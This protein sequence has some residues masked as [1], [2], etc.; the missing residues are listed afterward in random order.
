MRIQFVP[1]GSRQKSMLLK[2]FQPAFAL[3]TVL[4]V[5]TVM[6][7]VLLAAIQTSVS[8]SQTINSQYKEKISKEAA[9]SGIAMAKACLA[10]PPYSI[11]WADTRSLKPSTD[12]SGG[13]LTICPASSTS[14][15]CYVLINSGFRTKFSV[16]VTING[17]NTEIISKG[18]ADEIRKTSLTPVNRTTYT[19][20]L[21]VS[22]MVNQR[23]Y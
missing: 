19:I 16:G 3:P 18:F 9:E 8:V 14:A 20:K 15:A 12:C 23:A 21:N 10:L 11:Q 22:D 5:A 13:D 6:L 2:S 1:S 17:S 7:I 4:I